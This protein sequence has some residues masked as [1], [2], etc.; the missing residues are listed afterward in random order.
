MNR[1]LMGL[2]PEPISRTTIWSSSWQELLDQEPVEQRTNHSYSIN[3]RVL[4]NYPELLALITRQVNEF[5]ESVLGI[6]EPLTITQS[7]I[8]S[9]TPGQH[10]HRHNH[11][12][13]VVSGT[14]YWST[15]DTEILF[16]KHSLNSS[17]TWTMK[18]D[19]SSNSDTPFAVQTNA[20]RVA[21]N[22]LLL[23]PSYLQHS[24]ADHTGSQ[25]RKTLSFNSMPRTWG[26]D[27]YRVI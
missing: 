7:W 19:Q 9:Y 22:D 10:I 5:S 21:E 4:H 20:I 27:L 6:K 17:Q 15:P 12:N 3:D 25:P 2:F 1:Q 24:T 23:W 14:W 18:L 16:H 26:S 13:S 8:N 11:P